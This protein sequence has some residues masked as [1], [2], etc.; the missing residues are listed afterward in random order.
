MNEWKNEFPCHFS[1]WGFHMGVM[2]SFQ[3]L[4]CLCLIEG[5]SWNSSVWSLRLLQPAIVSLSSLNV[6]DFPP[7]DI[8]C[9]SL[10]TQPFHISEPL[11][12][13]RPLSGILI[14][15]SVL[16]LGT[17]FKLSDPLGRMHC[18]SI[19]DPSVCWVSL[20]SWTGTCMFPWK[21]SMP[22]L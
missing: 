8:I 5:W 10:N 11:L 18:S 19:C 15:I 6:M 21:L 1:D 13:Q 2:T 9:T 12:R 17:L 20:Q 14:L 16:T 22:L 3:K 4:C 7:W